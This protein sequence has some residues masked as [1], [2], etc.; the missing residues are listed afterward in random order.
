MDGRRS[1]IITS[2]IG[3]YF[4]NASH[5]RI[6]MDVAGHDAVPILIKRA[7]ERAESDVGHAQL[8]AHKLPAG[9]VYAESLDYFIDKLGA[10]Q[11][12]ARRGFL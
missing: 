5:E 6:I 2:K 8:L 7:S 10:R 1:G 4:E 9:A 12:D 11:L 3:N